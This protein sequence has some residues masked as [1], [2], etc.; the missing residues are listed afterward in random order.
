[1]S[2]LCLYRRAITLF[3][4]GDLRLDRHNRRQWVRS[5]TYLGDRWLLAKPVS[6]VSE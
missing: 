6:K 4:S 2:A 3:N 1:M 5:V